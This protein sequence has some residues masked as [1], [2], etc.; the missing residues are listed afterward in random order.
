MEFPMLKR[1]LHRGLALLGLASLAGCATPSQQSAGARPALWQVSDPDTTVYLFG[2]IHRLPQGHN[3]TSPKLQDA[4][5]R[6]QELVVELDLDPKDSQAF[7][8]ELYRLGFG[9][10]LQPLAQRVDPSMRAALEQA[11]ARSGQTRAS[12]DQMET[13][14]AGFMLLIQRF[15]ELQLSGE[16]GVEETLKRNFTAQGKPIRQ[17]ETITEQLSI[18]D[19]LP[20]KAQ[21]ELLHGAIGPEQEFRN[22]FNEMLA[23]WT[24]GDV[25]AIAAAFNKDLA[26]SP[27][28]REALIRRRNA[29]WSRW[30]ERRLVSP[31]TVMVA[32]GAGHLAGNDS[33]IA[34]LQR[35]GYKVRRVQ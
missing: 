9:R 15:Q 29:N 21:R 11:I 24:R 27:E 25:E 4:F 28:L 8:R 19:T 22:Q 7:V 14:A 18:F 17:L 16:A 2:T 34:A 31:G 12:F 23:A 33:V 3:W 26:A 5:T 6:S 1:I 20:E 32:V 30:V 35:D 10:N 13:W